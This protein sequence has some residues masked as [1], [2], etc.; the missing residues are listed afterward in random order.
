[1]QRLHGS[2]ISG[3]GASYRLNR[4]LGY[5]EEGRRR[6]HCVH[7]DGYNDVIAL[8]LLVDEF[9]EQRPSMKPKLYWHQAAPEIT[10]AARS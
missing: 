2:L 6:K 10:T 3:N 1:M 9:R 5:V 7:P 4:F 8:G